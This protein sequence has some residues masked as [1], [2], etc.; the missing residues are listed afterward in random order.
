MW[1]QK[2]TISVGAL[3][4]LLALGSASEQQ[5]FKN[6]PRVNLEAGHVHRRQSTSTP[7]GYSPD[8]GLC[9]TG[10]TC[11]DACGPN[12]ESCEASTTLSLFCYN[13]VD[14]KQTCCACEEGYYCAWQE[15]GGKVWCCEDR[16]VFPDTRFFD[17]HKVQPNSD[18]EWYVVFNQLTMP[19]DNRDFMGNNNRGFNGQHR[20]HHCD[21]SRTGWWML[22][23][24]VNLFVGQRTFF[25]HFT[26]GH[27]HS[28]PVVILDILWATSGKTSTMSRNSS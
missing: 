3:Q 22:L 8:F 13:K 7:P 1:S 21:G 28:A 5:V 18:R 4:L 16:A 14:L 19:C 27:H 10:T 11:Q 24:V 15:F 6:T 26:F 2:L 12:W 25:G 17:L 23:R 20:G 9:G